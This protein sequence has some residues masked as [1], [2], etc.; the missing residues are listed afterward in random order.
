MRQ[1]LAV[2]IRRTALDK[3]HSKMLNYREVG[4]MALP[5]ST[6]IRGGS[7]ATRIGLLLVLTTDLNFKTV[8]IVEVNTGLRF[9]LDL[10]V[11]TLQFG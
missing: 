7:R 4:V 10:D 3:L 11:T 5:G 6:G 1:V 9:P 2:G 8:W